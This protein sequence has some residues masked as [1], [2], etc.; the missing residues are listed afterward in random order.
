M[1]KNLISFVLTND[2]IFL[3]YHI[4]WRIYIH[5]YT[6]ILIAIYKIKNKIWL[7]LSL[8]NRELSKSSTI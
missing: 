8:H 2:I 6:H 4:N 3:L 7:I 5:T 1:Q